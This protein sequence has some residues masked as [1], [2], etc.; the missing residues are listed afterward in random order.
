VGRRG[1]GIELD[2]LY[3]DLAILRWQRLTKQTAVH[4]S[5]ATFDALRA[6]RRGA[7]AQD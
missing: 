7:R 6:E 1:Y 4:A 3:V 2:P 5:G